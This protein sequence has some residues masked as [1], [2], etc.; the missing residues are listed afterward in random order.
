LVAFAR[1]AAEMV[2]LTWLRGLEDTLEETG[3]GLVAGVDEVGRG[4]LAGPVTVAAYVSRPGQQVPGVDDSKKLTP[5]LREALAPR[6]REAALAWCVVSIS[7]ADIDTSDILEATRRGTTAALEGLGV[8]LGWA[9]TDALPLPAERLAGGRCVATVKADALC[10]SVAC[11][12]ILAKVARDRHMCE[13]D[14]A[15]PQFDF[16]RN[17]GYGSETHLDALR[18]FGPSREHRLSFSSV[19][20]RRRAA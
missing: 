12:S 13:L 16:A 19:T 14:R 1:V 11:A 8:P 17:K 10:Y 9:L 7:A 20:P 15:Y 4:C 2:R 5:E 18:R 6:L 3:L